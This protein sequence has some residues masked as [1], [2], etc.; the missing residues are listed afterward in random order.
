MQSFPHRG[1]R[2]DDIR[3]GLRITNYKKRPVIAFAVDADRV[4]IIG[5]F[6][7]GQDYEADLLSDLDG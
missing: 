4:S 1:T 2:R 7:G 3:T 5:V 6:Y